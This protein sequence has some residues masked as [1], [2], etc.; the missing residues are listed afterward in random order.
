MFVLHF[1][2][3]SLDLRDS[4]IFCRPSFSVKWEWHP[5]RRILSFW[6]LFLQPFSRPVGTFS[7]IFTFLYRILYS[8]MITWLFNRFRLLLL[9]FGNPLFFAFCLF[10]LGLLRFAWFFV[11][12]IIIGFLNIKRI[13]LVSNN[14][15]NVWTLA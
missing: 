13:I 10:V 6:L 7:F 15:S 3:I 1:W 14:A 11:I 2:G 4:L 9:L 8:L 12:F 5:S